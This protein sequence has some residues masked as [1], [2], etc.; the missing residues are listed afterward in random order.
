LKA[1]STLTGFS[2]DMLTVI[3]YSSQLTLTATFLIAVMFVI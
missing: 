2:R 3:A 1:A